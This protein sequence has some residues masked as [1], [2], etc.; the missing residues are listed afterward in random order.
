MYLLP[1][2]F[3]G[4]P[5]SSL[6]KNLRICRVRILHR[7]GVL[8][9]LCQIHCTLCSFYSHLHGVGTYGSISSH[10]RWGILN[11]LCFFLFFSFFPS[12]AMLTLSFKGG[13]LYNV[14]NYCVSRLVFMLLSLL[15]FLSSLLQ[16]SMVSR[17][18]GHT[19]EVLYYYSFGIF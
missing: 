13:I 2:V 7:N 3:W 19:K 17:F 14:K 18:L 12:G 8:C 4:F 10:H 16:I 6:S 11:P 15:S 9:L 1:T 5:Y